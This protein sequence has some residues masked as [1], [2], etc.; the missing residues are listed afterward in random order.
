MTNAVDI[1]LEIPERYFTVPYSNSSSISV[2]SHRFT[3]SRQKI[4][5]IHLKLNHHLTTKPAYHSP[6]ALRQ[7]YR[8]HR[9]HASASRIEDKRGL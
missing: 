1:R 4:P 2:F 7:R 6:C 9:Q 3:A 8:L 5:R